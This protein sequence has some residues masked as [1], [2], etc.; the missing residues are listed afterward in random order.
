MS[1]ETQ[2]ELLAIYAE[3]ERRL[4]SNKMD[5]VFLDDGPLRRDLYGKV[6]EFFEAGAK[7]KLRLYMAANRVGK[8]FGAAYEIACHLTGNYPEWWTGKRFQFS[9]NWWVCGVDSR[10]VQQ[11]LQTALLGRIGEF[12]TGFIPEDSLDF[13]SLKDAKKAD[14][15]I[16]T[17]RVMHKSG[18]YSG[19]SFKSYESGR[20]AFQS[21]KVNIWLDEEPPLSIFTECMLRTM[22]TGT[23]DRP[24]LMM[25]FT[26]LK[27]LSATVM[28]FLEGD[29]FS[30][31]EVLNKDLKPTGKYVVRCG[32]DDVPHLTEE[33]KAL[34]IESIPPWARDARTK[35]IPQMGSGVIYPIAWEQI[36]FPRFE[37][38]EHWKRYAGMDVGNKTACIWLAI[39]PSTGVSYAYHEYYREGE[40]PAV[41][42]A[43][44][45]LPGSWIP[46]AIDHAAHGRS[47]IDGENLF[48]LY[49]GFGLVLHNANKAV[50]SGLY[51]VWE[52]L[53][54]NRV[55]VFSD[56]QRFKK[57]YLIYQKDEKGRVVKTDDHIMDCFRYAIMT[58]RD[59]AVN[60][61]EATPT[62]YYQTGVS[63]QYRPNLP[64]RGR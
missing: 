52:L 35:G 19:V 27:G 58:G 63:P 61:Q 34:L 62:P 22:D 6:M 14:T 40:L 44:I 57:E 7:Y 50:E 28:S 30:E 26:P 47:Q 4:R 59:L 2:E 49:K 10:L 33:D 32:W 1:S 46:I 25:T 29:T 16:N 51:T 53:A 15:P 31:G 37:I 39:D 17:F 41:H 9:N 11:E 60:K 21:A 12:G 20:E 23:G 5:T 24:I 13:D 3:L 55:K 18:T 8:T 42:A 64:L 38:P 43:S 56:L 54:S 48:D 45:A 36:S